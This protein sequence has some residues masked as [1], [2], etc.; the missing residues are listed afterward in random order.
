MPVDITLHSAKSSVTK[1]IWVDKD[2]RVLESN[3]SNNVNVI[4]YP[5][6]AVGVKLLLKEFARRLN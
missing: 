6:N 2:H 3:R 4:S 1:R 5:K